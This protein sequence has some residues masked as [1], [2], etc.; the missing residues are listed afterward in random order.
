MDPLTLALGLSLHLGFEETYN[1]VHPHIRY[2]HESLIAGIYYNS[3]EKISTYVG[4]RLE[5]NDL[6]FE[7]GAVTGYSGGTVIPFIRGT[8][9]NYFIAPG[10]EGDNIGIVL[11]TE[12]KF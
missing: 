7:Y 12:L 3:E 6:G 1:P 8:Y 10:V 2:Q 9:K 5:Y 11:G 4:Q